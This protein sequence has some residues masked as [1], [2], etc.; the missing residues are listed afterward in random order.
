M[1]KVEEYQ[2]LVRERTQTAWVASFFLRNEHEED[3]YEH[4]VIRVQAFLRETA[5]GLVYEYLVKEYPHNEGWTLP[6]IVI[7]D[8]PFFIVP[9][10]KTLFIFADD[11]EET[12][13]TC[14]EEGSPCDVPEECPNNREFSEDSGEIDPGTPSA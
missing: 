7:D 2:K 8:E 5:L 3:E 13:P 12:C 6:S 4:G 11:E 10:I 14:G 1:T 9:S